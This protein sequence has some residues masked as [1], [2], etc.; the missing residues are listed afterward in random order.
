MEHGEGQREAIGEEFV[1]PS[2]GFAESQRDGKEEIEDGDEFEDT[3][4]CKHNVS[5]G[6]EGMAQW[7]ED[8]L[9]HLRGGH[10][11]DTTKSREERQRYL[12]GIVDTRGVSGPDGR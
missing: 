1:P 10:H 2:F 7:R 4:L 5:A 6:S 3:L 9:D 11:V 8:L 12:N